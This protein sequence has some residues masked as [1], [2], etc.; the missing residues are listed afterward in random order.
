MKTWIEEQERVASMVSIPS[1]DSFVHGVVDVNQ[2]FS[3]LAPS[4]ISR[5]SKGHSTLFG[6]LDVSFDSNDQN[7][8]VAV[9]VV[10]DEENFEI[11][12]Q[13]T[14][15]FEPQDVPYIP[16]FLAFREWQPLVKLVRKQMRDHPQFTPTVLF[17]DGNGLLHPRGAG[18]ACFIGVEAGL[19]SVGIGKNLYNLD[20]LTKDIV[21]YGLSMSLSEGCKQLSEL[22]ILIETRKIKSVLVDRQPVSAST[23]GNIQ[24]ECIASVTVSNKIESL[25]ELIPNCTG[26]AVPLVCKRVANTPASSSSDPIAYALL[27]HGGMKIGTS[28]PI[29]VSVG[30]G[31][32]LGDAVLLSASLAKHRIPEPVR[33][34]DLIGR[35]VLRKQQ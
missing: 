7:I 24:K 13:D 35:D 16:S 9:Y 14:E 25:R 4:V 21:M 10:L 5:P 2:R 15:I 6:G 17:V 26:F 31:I 11:V 33:Q 23:S 28:K 32:T 20:G 34:A 30:H 22:S 1:K 8:A 27:G 19:S 12:Y 29:Y 3:L 18:L